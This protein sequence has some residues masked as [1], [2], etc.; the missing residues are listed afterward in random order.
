MARHPTHT[1]TTRTGATRPMDSRVPSL[2]GLPQAK[3]W[4]THFAAQLPAQRRHRKLRAVF[5]TAGWRV[6][7]WLRGRASRTGTAAAMGHS[8]EWVAMLS[9]SIIDIHHR[10]PQASGAARDAID[11]EITWCEDDRREARGSTRCARR[12]DRG[13]S[14]CVRDGAAVGGLRQPSA[15]R[16][17]A[18]GGTRRAARLQRPGRAAF[19]APTQRCV[20]SHPGSAL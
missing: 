9:V 20:V 6:K 13:G 11:S 5:T 18:G 1:M 4:I 14:A 2:A 8:F 16:K 7:A 3:E 15:R 12:A 10:R 19:G 17:H